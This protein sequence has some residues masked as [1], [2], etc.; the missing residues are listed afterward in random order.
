MAYAGQL[1]L[2]LEKGSI[3]MKKNLLL[4]MVLA[5]LSPFAA[6]ESWKNVPVIDSQCSM[7]A[8]ADPDAH[9]RSCA[10]ACSKSGF[11]IIDEKGHYL[12]FDTKGN[13]EALKLLQESN[14]K[15]HLRVDVS[16]T[17]DGDTIQVESLSLM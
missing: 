8:K 15:D 1:E 9:T 6:A 17:L 16:G 3:R 12:K 11:G 14:K 5:A 10:L 7:K 13:Q 4:L 2:S